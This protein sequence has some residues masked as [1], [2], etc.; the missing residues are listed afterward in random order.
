[1][2]NTK[3]GGRPAALAQKPRG[4]GARLR[5]DLTARSQ[6]EGTTVLETVALA[7]SGF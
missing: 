3:L 2:Q 4:A 7:A 1:M 6:H 5:D